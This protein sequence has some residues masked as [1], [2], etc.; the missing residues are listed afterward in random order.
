MKTSFNVTNKA[1]ANATPPG[2]EC[3]SCDDCKDG[4]SDQAC[5]C[6]PQDLEHR[7]MPT[8]SFKPVGQERR[9]ITTTG[10]RLTRKDFM[11]WSRKEGAQVDPIVWFTEMGHGPVPD[12]VT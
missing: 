10:K 4:T 3:S 6:I 2:E 1:N 7:V 5:G 8:G 12:D 11:E 9:Y